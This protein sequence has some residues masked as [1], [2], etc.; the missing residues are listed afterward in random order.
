MKVINIIQ[1]MCRIDKVDIEY[2]STGYFSTLR[3]RPIKFRVYT[4]NM[5]DFGVA[6]SISIEEFRDAYCIFFELNGSIVADYYT[7]DILELN[8]ENISQDDFKQ[9]K[10]GFDDL[11]KDNGGC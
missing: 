1:K 6:N 7:P 11:F 3:I 4:K 9:F 2:C 8:I 5:F 10:R